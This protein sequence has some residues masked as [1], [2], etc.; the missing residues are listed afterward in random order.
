[1]TTGFD[2]PPR[3]IRLARIVKENGGRLLLVGGCVRDFLMGRE[4]KDYDAEVFGIEQT[5]LLE[6]LKSFGRVNAVGESFKVYK[7]AKDLD[8]SLPRRER[9]QGRGH[10]GFIVEGDHT[11]SFKEAARRR[12]F[13]I[14]A[15]ML[16][17]LTLEV[18]DE[19]DGQSDLQRKV[20]CAVDSETFIEDSL[21]VLRAAQFA[22]RFE[23]E[24]ESQTIE[25]C[26]GINLSD[27]PPERIWGE[28]EKLLLQAAR[29]SIGL[30]W[31]E[32]LNAARQVLPEIAALSETAKART[33]EV[34]NNARALVDDLS[35][36]KQI[37]VM[38]AAMCVELNEP[39]TASLLERLRVFTFDNYDVRRQV[40]ALVEHQTKPVEFYN[41][42]ASNG[43]LRR[44]A[45]RCELG[46]LWRIAAACSSNEDDRTA[47][48]WFIS[49]ARELK[50]ETKP[51]PPLLQG[52]HLQQLGLEPSPQFGVILKQVYELQLD[53]R[54]TTLDEAIEAAQRLM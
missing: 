42:R 31:L 53:D 43:S 8:V 29:P 25:L 54:L 50:I 51:P 45:A 20:L 47:C 6:L 44:L 36:A 15:V 30:K 52:R 22:A 46:L 16:D 11:L 14:N 17:A 13:T 37:A 35:Y 49:R 24:V 5:R 3:V 18:I 4:P 7:L 9:K 19:F 26:R 21:R 48:E 33:F 28:I 1:M 39:Q 34:V 10:K 23:F 38:L 32:E 12:D 40:L 41:S 2:I 27:L